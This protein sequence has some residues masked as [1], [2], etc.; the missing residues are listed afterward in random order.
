MP[1]RSLLVAS[2]V[3]LATA[4]SAQTPSPQQPP[5]TCESAEHRQFDFWVGVWE[6]VM[7]NGNV[8]GRNTITREM[9]G[10]VIHEH[11]AGAAGLKGESF[12][13]FDRVTKRW[14]QTWVT[15]RGNLLQLDGAFQ[16]GRMQLSGVSGPPDQK[17]MNRITWTPAPD[18]TLRQMWE[19]SNDGGKSWTTAFD[20]SYRQ[21]KK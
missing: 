7:P 17:V 8:A 19:T 21:L 9:N 6:V 2:I 16:N 11:W 13:I 18:G 3:A 10:C 14:H 4:A 1:A 5:M 12:N 15:D 20:G